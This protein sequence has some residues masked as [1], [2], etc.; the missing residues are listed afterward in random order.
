MWRRADHSKEE[1]E[2]KRIKEVVH[3]L[4]MEAESRLLSDEELET[5]RLGYKDIIEM[6][7]MG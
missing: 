7:K 4:D 6:E 1:A 3:K 5:R 2:L